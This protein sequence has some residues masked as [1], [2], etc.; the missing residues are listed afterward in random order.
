[1]QNISQFAMI[2]EKAKCKYINLRTIWK[3][4]LTKGRNE[5]IKT[6]LETILNS[7]QT[8]FA[9]FFLNR[10]YLLGS[11]KNLANAIL[12]STLTWSL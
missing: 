9:L 5:Y 12:V 8:L 2:N 4:N 6:N 10:K 11:P 7:V 1:M 3:A